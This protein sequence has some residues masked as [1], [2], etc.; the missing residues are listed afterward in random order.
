[1]SLHNV[2]IPDQV[3]LFGILS[4]L[5][6]LLAWGRWRYDVVALLALLASVIF[7]LVPARE[8]FL[9]FGHPAT[10]TV[11]AILVLS[12]ALSNVGATDRIAKIVEPGTARTW[13]HI[14]ALSS[15]AAV[16]SSFMNNV[17]T[18]G[19]L[20]PVAMQTAQKAKRAAA[21]VLMPLS[22]GSILGGMV[23]VIG[24]PPNIIVATYRG[25]VFG[26]DFGMFD[27]TPV[28][29]VTALAGVVFVALI[30]WRLVPQR[31]RARAAPAE[32]FDIEHYVAEATVK[33]D[34]KAV[35]KSLAEAAEA[36]EDI[37]VLVV[38]VIRNERMISSRT[39]WL[40]LDAGDVMVVEGAPE[41]LDKFASAL[42]LD[43][44][45]N[46]GEGA[47]A[48]GEAG[49]TLV[50]AVVGP[51]SR[52]EGQSVA[53]QRIIARHGYTLLAVA[54]QGRP[55]RGRLRNFR[56]RVGDVLLL[57]G[58]SDRVPEALAAFGCLPLAARGLSIGQ[59][60]KAP[61]LILIFAAAIAAATFRLVPIEIAL[62]CAV[63]GAVL[64]NIMPIRELYDGVDWPVIVLLGALIPVGGALESTGASQTV[65][66]LIRDITGDQPPVI[67]LVLLMIATMTLSDV[68]NN[69]ATAVIMAPIGV[70]IAKSLGVSGD[71]FLMAVAVGASCAFLTP[72]GHQNNALVM[73]PGGYRFGDYW[74]MGL[75]L[76]VLIVA[77]SV[78]MI[79][80]VWP[81]Y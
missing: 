52:L 53:S 9:G 22:F 58:E 15:I 79:L 51:R 44:A 46:G 73:G 55:Y 4:G 66:D 6:L 62:S 24:T 7:G 23:T 54:R 5:F 34:G 69:A 21:T 72:I 10:I 31:A 25:D 29:A 78:P 11:A 48:L 47:A 68:L 75:P 1:M 77:V 76:E 65:A 67:A 41:A 45:A 38:G 60:H 16:M 32:V 17:G 20:M 3:A 14:A 33:E 59:R 37:D 13:S 74:R 57:H 42:G 26:R 81:L 49:N 19:L 18:L 50:E 28:G 71:P 80:W 43:L 70:G 27:F 61:A 56:F 64:F 8:A 63:A 12:R 40:K 2:A 35:G 30:G 39:Q 36:T